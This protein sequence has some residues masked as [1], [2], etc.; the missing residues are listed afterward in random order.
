LPLY[1]IKKIILD[2]LTSLSILY[3]KFEIMP[4]VKKAVEQ[5]CLPREIRINACLEDDPEGTVS[6][7]QYCLTILSDLIAFI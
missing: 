1:V 3:Y 7:H 2:L 5:P 4:R 6:S